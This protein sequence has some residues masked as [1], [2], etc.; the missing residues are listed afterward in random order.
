MRRIR[1]HAGTLLLVVLGLACSRNPEPEPVEP[2]PV[3]TVDTT[4][5]AAAEAARREA[6]ANRLCERALAAI[7]A[8]NFDVARDLYRQV[9]REYPG[10]TCA[11]TADAALT[12]IESLEAIVARVHFEFDKSRITDEAAEVL[13]RKA[14]ALRAHPGVTLTIEGHCDERG[15]L[16][17]N[18]ALGMRRAESVQRYLG[19]LGLDTSRFRTVSFGEERPL[20]PE[21]NEA[22]WAMNRRGEFIVVDPGDL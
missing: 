15:S 22:A 7:E 18:M 20:V 17:Y 5:D 19:S 12:R 9:Q 13:Q 8:G 16:E 3:E 4:D 11:G 14:D 21:S 2:E 6:E 1:P 10:T